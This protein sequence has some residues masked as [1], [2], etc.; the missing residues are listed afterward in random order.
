MPCNK[1]NKC[2]VQQS[3]TNPLKY[4]ITHLIV[5]NR[6]AD[7]QDH[8]LLCFVSIPYVCNQLPKEYIPP[9]VVARS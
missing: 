5:K 9:Y 1:A 7:C 8:R 4:N 3:S 6:Q 2:V